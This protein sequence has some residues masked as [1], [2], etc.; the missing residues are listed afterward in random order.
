MCPEKENSLVAERL[1]EGGSPL[2]ALDDDV[3]RAEC[4]TDVNTGTPAA[5]NAAL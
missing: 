1:G 5:R 4:G 3:G 2:G